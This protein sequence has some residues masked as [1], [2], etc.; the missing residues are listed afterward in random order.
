MNYTDIQLAHRLCNASTDASALQNAQGIIQQQMLDTFMYYS[1]KLAKRTYEY[2]SGWNFIT[3]SGVRVRITDDF[4][5]SITRRKS[6]GV[7]DAYHWIVNYISKK[8][9]YYERRD[10]ASLKHYINIILSK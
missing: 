5:S 7:M 10:N 8:C 9:C 4:P 3:S 2:R 6:A 1:K